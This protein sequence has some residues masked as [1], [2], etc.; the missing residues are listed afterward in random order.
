MLND[1]REAARRA[2]EFALNPPTY[3]IQM[4]RPLSVRE[5]E[6]I[7]WQIPGGAKIELSIKEPEPKYEKKTWAQ[8]PPEEDRKRTWKDGYA[9]PSGVEQL[10]PPEPETQRVW[11]QQYNLA[12]NPPE[13]PRPRLEVEYDE[14]GTQPDLDDPMARAALPE[15]LAMSANAM[16]FYM[17]L[18]RHKGSI[19]YDDVDEMTDGVRRNYIHTMQAVDRDDKDE[20]L[21]EGIGLANWA[22]ILVYNLATF[23]LEEIQDYQPILERLKREGK[24]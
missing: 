23:E 24:A 15:M 5:G 13:P 10:R 12:P 3:H 9:L 19:L 18:H 1:I 2:E 6:R 11:E 21:A 16:R 17:E 7:E 20:I 8:S 22:C 4:D 14:Q